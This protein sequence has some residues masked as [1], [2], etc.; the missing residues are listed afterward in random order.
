MSLELSYDAA[1]AWWAKA[2]EPQVAAMI[3]AV[4]AWAQDLGDDWTLDPQAS[5]QMHRVL[6]EEL[7]AHA[8]RC[9]MQL[10]DIPEWGALPDKAKAPWIEVMEY[11]FEPGS[12]GAEA[13]QVVR[14]AL[15]PPPFRSLPDGEQVHL[16]RQIAGE[17]ETYLEHD[18]RW[19]SKATPAYR[20]LADSIRR[21]EKVTN[22]EAAER[23]TVL[24]SHMGMSA[25][26]E[27][28]GD[29]APFARSAAREDGVR[30]PVMVELVN[31][32]RSL[33]RILAPQRAVVR[34]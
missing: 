8:R 4:K 14:Q 24:W 29:I 22:P 30:T 21:L 32:A 15:A 18:P 17:I 1:E 19:Y 20:H 6:A 28:L 12:R 34:E 26:D 25:R 5:R 13:A 33:E 7:T 3:G 31:L 23:C 16:L 10:T 9:D 2:T 27:V 11:V